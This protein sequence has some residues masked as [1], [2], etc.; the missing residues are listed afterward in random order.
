[1]LGN[2]TGSLTIGGY[3]ASRLI[4]NDVTFSFNNAIVRQ[5]LVA[6]QGIT[7]TDPDTETAVLPQSILAL[8]DST[9]PHIWLPT[10][11]CQSFEDIFGMT[12]DPIRN[13]YLINDTQ[14]DAMLKQNATISFQLANSLNGGSAVNI[15]LPYASFDLEV[16]SP[17][18]RRYFP[19]KQAKSETQYTLGRTFLQEA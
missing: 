1:M 10:A 2:A 16:E 15:T 5:L 6:I 12:W 8:V 17:S 9:I 7:V 14:H 3:D 4:P 11:V 13:L 18:P 19:L